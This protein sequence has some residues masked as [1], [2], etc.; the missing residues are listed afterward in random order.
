MWYCFTHLCTNIYFLSFS[1]AVVVVVSVGVFF[2]LFFRVVGSKVYS[3]VCVYD[4]GNV[5]DD[6]DDDD[7]L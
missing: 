3:F 4:E 2:L 6:G 1:L 7:T 5:G